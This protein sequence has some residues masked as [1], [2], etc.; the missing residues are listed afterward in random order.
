M[1]NT[2]PVYQIIDHPTLTKKLSKVCM[3]E[4]K[5]SEVESVSR[6]S[7]LGDCLYLLTEDAVRGLSDCHSVAA[8]IL[9][10][11]TG[12]PYVIDLKEAFT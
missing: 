7:D 5:D 4:L 10:I 8:T 2:F 12:V 3:L 9:A 6:L 1:I 11:D